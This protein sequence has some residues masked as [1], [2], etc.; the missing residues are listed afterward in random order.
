VALN[1]ADLVEHA[2]DLVPDR[3]A[4]VCG[5]REIT[6]AQM[7]DRTNRLAHYLQKQ[8]VKPGD[9]VGV[10]SRNGIETIESMIAVFK[11]RAVV[12]NVNYRYIENEL[13]YIFQNSDMVAL[14]HEA[15]YSDKVAA[16]LPTCP[17]LKTTI[18]IGDAADGQVSY[19]EALEQSSPERDFAE[20]SGDDIYML[21]TG[22]TTGSPKGVMWRHEDVW[23][24]L[25]GGINFMTGEYLEDEWDLA[26]LGAENPVMTRMPIPPMIHGGAQWATFQS[27]FG[28]GKTVLHPD[29]DGHTI[30]Q[31]V[32]KH[33][34]NLIF[35]TGDAMARPM[36]DALIEGGPDGKPYDLSTLYLMASSA[37][38][39]SPSIKEKFLE[40]L[41]N[42]MLTD[43]IGSSETGFGGLSVVTKGA[44]HT[45]GPRVKIDASTSVLGEDGHPVEPGSG[46]KGLLARR[47]HIPVGYYKD[48][49]KTAATFKEIHGVRYSIPG[50]YAQV[51][52]DGTVTMLGRGSVS[53]N[54]G[55]EKVFPE[56][57]EGA[58]KS[59][60][61]V[62]DAIVVGVP[63]ERLGHMVAA[64]VQARGEERP[65]LADLDAC[66]RKEIA[67]YKVPRAVWFVDEIKRSP[68]GKPDYRWAVQQTELRPADETNNAHLAQRR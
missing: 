47:G 12:V 8:G 46:Q 26:K 10:Y 51:E 36:L 20:R 65:S 55:G 30:W 21:Y 37:A 44:E 56:E 49:A 31:L 13:Q 4:L 16:V 3:V 33:G 28:G 48:E 9:K 14:I 1:I 38:L 15:R 68:A 60:P 50:D 67:G 27:L 2:V 23:R 18:V 64:V 22:G 29:F 35:I 43:S 6:Y 52:V 32:D 11:L 59:H 45:G 63:D 54:T 53:I 7:E 40:L 19:D 5:D 17:L 57:V 42:R 25:G 24:V 41:P 66:A 39:F 34:I 61:E 62:F 58:L